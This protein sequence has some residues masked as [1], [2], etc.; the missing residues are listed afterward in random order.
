MRPRNRPIPGREEEH[1]MPA[2]LVS[3]AT[4]VAKWVQEKQALEVELSW[5]MIDC[6]NKPDLLN[7]IREACRNALEDMIIAGKNSLQAANAVKQAIDDEKANM[8]LLARKGPAKNPNLS[9]AG[10]LI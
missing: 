3:N 10:K 6:F 9:E 1:R 4:D 5:E 8:K 2:T 7:P